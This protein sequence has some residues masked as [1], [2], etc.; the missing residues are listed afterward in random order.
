MSVS[1]RGRKSVYD[2][3]I[4]PSFLE[5]AEWVRKGATE[6]DIMKRLGV[7][8]TT[9]NKYKN[10]KPE[11]LEII[12]KNRMDA[13]DKIENAMFTSATG[14]L[15]KIKKYAKCRHVEYED[16]KRSREY[17]TMEAYEEEV[18][19]PPNTTAGIYLLKHWAKDRG[20][21]NDPLTLELKKQELELRKEIAENNNW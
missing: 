10:E 12:K 1:K 20:Y 2:A 11:L 16:G 3:K 4:K 14:E 21:T 17:E 5:I 18:Y 13:V 19:I 6:A 15:R 7:S 9:F 8:H